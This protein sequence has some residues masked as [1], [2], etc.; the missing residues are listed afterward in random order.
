MPEPCTMKNCSFSK[1]KVCLLLGFYLS[2][3][4]QPLSNRWRI[5]NGNQ[6]RFTKRWLEKNQK[7]MVNHFRTSSRGSIASLTPE[8]TEEL[9]DPGGTHLFSRQWPGRERAGRNQNLDIFLFSWFLYWWK[10]PKR[11]MRTRVHRGQLPGA[12][13]RAEKGREL[14]GRENG[15]HMALAQFPYL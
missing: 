10:N 15:K 13:S 4:W 14:F 6:R 8:G 5:E 11:S 9:L 2:P 7:M 1:S 3:F 12:Q